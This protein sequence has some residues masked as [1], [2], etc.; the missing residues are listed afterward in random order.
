[1]KNQ[2]L[3]DIHSK[4]AAQKEKN[5]SNI[6]KR[7]ATRKQRSFTDSREFLKIYYLQK[8]SR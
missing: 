6:Q 8:S 7:D 4:S 3:V 2:A 1:M 5:E